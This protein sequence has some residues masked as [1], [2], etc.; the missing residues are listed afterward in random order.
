MGYKWQE[1][2]FL[3]EISPFSYAFSIAHFVIPFSQVTYAHSLLPSTHVVVKSPSASTTWVPQRSTAS[4]PF[5][6][7]YGFTLGYISR[8]VSSSSCAK[9]AP[10]SPSTQQA[11]LHLLRLQTNSSRISSSLTSTFPTSNFPDTAYD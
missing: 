3:H 11:P 5:G 8:K 10:E 6:V 7:M 1:M 9:G 4:M 2:G